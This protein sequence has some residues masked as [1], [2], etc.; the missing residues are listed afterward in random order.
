MRNINPSFVATAITL[1]SFL[2]CVASFYQE[3]FSLERVGHQTSLISA[4]TQWREEEEK[5]RKCQRKG[6]RRG[7]RIINGEKKKKIRNCHRVGGVIGGGRDGGNS[8]EN[9]RMEGWIEGG[10]ITENSAG[11]EWGHLSARS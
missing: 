7:G 4:K 2:A 9:G 3:P 1:I 6:G 5:I 10:R 11:C 8:R